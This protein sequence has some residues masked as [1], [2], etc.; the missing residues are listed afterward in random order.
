MTLP[1]SPDILYNT[2]KQWRIQQVKV[3][4]SL[5]RPGQALRVPGG[6]GSQILKQLAHE[7][8]CT[9]RL[10]PPPPE[11]FLVLISVR[12]TEC[13]DYDKYNTYNQNP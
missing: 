3:T 9:G 13:P 10:Y 8:L 12:G 11:I 6:W 4:Q 5:Y 1:N 2:Y 7:A